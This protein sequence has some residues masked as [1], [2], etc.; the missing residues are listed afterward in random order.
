MTER[1]ASSAHV[2]LTRRGILRSGAAL[3]A[4]PAVGW[5]LAG[6][7]SAAAGDTV[8]T[9]GLNS[10]GQLGNGSTIRRRT[11][12]EVPGLANVDDVAGGREHALALVGGRV[13][14]WGD[15]AKAAL[16]TGD[17]VD[18]SSPAQVTLTGVVEIATAHYGS[19]ARMSDG[20]VRAWGYNASGQLGDGS[21][22]LRTRPVTVRKADGTPLTGVKQI[23]AGRDMAMALTTDGK[24]WTWGRGVDGELGNGT[25]PTAQTRAVVVTGL[26]GVKAIAGGR[27]HVLALMTDGTVKSWGA[28]GD[29]QLGLG[30]TTKRTKPVTVPGL[31]SVIAVRGGAEFSVA[32][33]A[34]GTMMTFGRNGRGQLGLGHTSKRLSPQLVVGPPAMARIGCGRDHALAVTTG[35]QL[36]GWGFNLDGQLGD[37]GSA[38]QLRPVAISGMTRVKGVHGGFGFSVVSRGAA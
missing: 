17:R 5:G 9:A 23:A 12:G 38:N 22:V 30:D 13:W 11:F 10:D 6:P 21:L 36:W 33:R 20:T 35:G 32:L 2:P 14:A 27:N 25:T 31:A 3:V 28:N 7:A 16:G 37:G 24:V 8:W 26:T 18:R 34:D 15:N 19:Y 4:A 1:W 29:G